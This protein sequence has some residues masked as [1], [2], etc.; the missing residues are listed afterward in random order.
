MIQAKL[1]KNDGI[2]IIEELLYTEVEAIEH[3][4]WYA[5]VDQS[6]VTITGKT[7]KITQQAYCLD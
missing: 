5:T 7:F 6:S 3:K 2:Y 1:V 4:S